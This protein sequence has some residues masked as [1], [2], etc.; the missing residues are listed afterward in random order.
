[1]AVASRSQQSVGHKVS[2]VNDDGI[3]RVPRFSSVDALGSDSISPLGSFLL[4]GCHFI[5]H[6]PIRFPVEINVYKIL[7][8]RFTGPRVHVPN[9]SAKYDRHKAAPDKLSL[10]RSKSHFPTNLITQ[11]LKYYFVNIIP[12]EIYAWV[13]HGASVANV[14]AEIILSGDFSISAF[15]SEVEFTLVAQD[16]SRC[17]L[18]PDENL[19]L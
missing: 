10:I 8:K 17:L 4:E 5:L 19:R 7:P 16:S 1:V 18:S 11:F 14:E 13:L 6:G 3:D 15:F 12:L 2:S 9:I